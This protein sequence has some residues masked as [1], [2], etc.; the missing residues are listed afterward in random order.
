MNIVDPMTVVFYF[1][2]GCLA[3]SL[4]DKVIKAIVEVTRVK[5]A[6]RNA[7]ALSKVKNGPTGV[8]KGK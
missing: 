3:L 1:L 5:L 2:M 7:D 6:V 8:V 4:V